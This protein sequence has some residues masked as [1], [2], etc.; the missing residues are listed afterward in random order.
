VE[1]GVYRQTDVSAPLSVD[2]VR[3]TQNGQPSFAAGD[4]LATRTLT[5]DQIPLLMTFAQIGVPMNTISVDF[6]SS[7]LSFSSGELI[8][9]VLRSDAAETPR[10]YSW[11]VATHPIDSYPAGGSYSLQYATN[12]VLQHGGIDTQF[13]TYVVVPEPSSLV[14]VGLSA[15]SLLNGR[16]RQA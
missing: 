4:R 2:I 12:M 3:T 13:A 7:G 1:L 5:K 8:G 9:I 15:L 6:L 11:W 10:N 14:L 16:K